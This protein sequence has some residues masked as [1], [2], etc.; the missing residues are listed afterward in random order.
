MPATVGLSYPL[1]TRRI[2][3]DAAHGYCCFGQFRGWI[4][5]W[6]CIFPAN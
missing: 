3:A 5:M 4:Y 2:D 1:I 6:F